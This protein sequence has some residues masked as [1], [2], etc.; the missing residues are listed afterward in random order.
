M[1]NSDQPW[2][3]LERE[4][5]TVTGFGTL[6]RRVSASENREM[7]YG[8]RLPDRR[9]AFILHVPRELAPLPEIL[10]ESKG[11]VF[12]VLVAGDEERVE[13]LSI[14]LSAARSEYHEVFATICDDLVEKLSTSASASDHVRIFVNRMR[15]WH[16]FFEKQGGGG[17]SEEAQQG[18]YGELYFLKEFMLPHRKDE[19]AIR[20]WT[21]S[22]GRQHDFQFGALSV[23]VKTSASK[24]HQVLRISSEQQLDDSL[25]DRLVLF[26]LSVSLV[27]NRA[28]TLP[29]I[30]DEIRQILVRSALALELFENA[31]L[32][33]GYSHAHRTMYQRTGYS[34]RSFGIYQVYDEFPRVREGDLLPGV[35]DV[36]YSITLD[37]CSDYALDEKEFCKTLAEALK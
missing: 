17:L 3:D 11:F 31:L 26:H 37:G 12:E 1:K 35:G 16:A 2:S 29:A 19:K 34:V 20:C 25:V 32:V 33:R 8:I 24:R 10:P 9:R 7:Y 15:L 4:A 30:I 18:L 36:F 28:T 14:I 27:E 13:D 6:K 5:S 21:G 22:V 23:E